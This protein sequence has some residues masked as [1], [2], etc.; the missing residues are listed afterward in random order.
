MLADPNPAA[1]VVANVRLPPESTGRDTSYL[2]GVI[3]IG[4]TSEPDR[5]IGRMTFMTFVIH[6]DSVTATGNILMVH[7]N[8]FEVA[9]GLVIPFGRAFRD[10]GQIVAS[11]I[12]GIHMGT[13]EESFGR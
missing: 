10:P 6:K 13:I 3:G 7:L 11:A 5:C 1:M 12:G 8:A 4:E 9:A 2:R